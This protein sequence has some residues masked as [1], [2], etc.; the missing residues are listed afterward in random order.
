MNVSASIKARF[1]QEEAHSKLGKMIVSLAEFSGVPKG[2]S[3]KVARI[4][5]MGRTPEEW[6]VEIEWNIL[7]R[8]KPLTDWFTKGEY[9]RYL[10]EV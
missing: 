2:T 8:F 10:R 9:E 7:E 4:D 6:D 3:G 1:S 5:R